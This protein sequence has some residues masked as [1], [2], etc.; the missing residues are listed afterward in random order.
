[1]RLGKYVASG[2]TLPIIWSMIAK[3]MGPALYFPHKLNVA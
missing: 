1:M 2:L 3:A